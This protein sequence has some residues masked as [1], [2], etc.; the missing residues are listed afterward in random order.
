MKYV[1]IGAGAA[2]I[3]AAKTIRENSDGEIVIISCD[4]AVYSRCMLHKFIGGQRDVAELSFIPENFFEQNK[5]TWHSGVTVTSID[6]FSKQVHFDGATESYE[7]LL[8]ATGAQSVLPSIEGLQNA[9]NVFGL[10]HLSDAKSIRESAS[11]SENIIIIGAGL[12]GLD[13][14]YGLVELGK[15]PTII[16]MATS[17]L[18]QNMDARA[19]E[20][21]KVK[22]EETGC[23][24]LLESKVTVVQTDS[25]GMVSHVRLVSGQELPCD[26]LIVAVGVQPS[27]DFLQ[28]SDIACGRGVTVNKYLATNQEGVYAAGDVTGISENWPDAKRQGEVAALNMCG[29]P[30]SYNDAQVQ[31]NTINFFNIP[32]LSVGQLVPCEG[33]VEESREAEVCYQKVITRD[34]VPVGVILQG[35]ISRNGFW[36]H[37]IKNKLSIAQ[38]QKSIWK[39]SFADSYGLDENGE[40]IWV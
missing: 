20:T 33:D 3:S 12:V 18:P 19:A 2:G 24:F 35:D 38:I 5:I 17:I 39:V 31:K 34:N 16:E 26:M 6:T 37:M 14:A 30:T 10:R 27:I 25:S 32:T 23:N 13:A 29:I 15:K 28:D 8:I 7:R 1:I 22:F 4:D 40:Y 36:Q 21:Y 9:K 11:V